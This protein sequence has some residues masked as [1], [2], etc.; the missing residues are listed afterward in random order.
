MLLPFSEHRPRLPLRKWANRQSQ[1][2]WVRIGVSNALVGGIYRLAGQVLVERQ[3]VEQRS[4]QGK[5]FTIL[6]PGPPFLDNFPL[7]SRDAAIAALEEAK[8]VLASAR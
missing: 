4:C 2:S 7:V 6:F 5:Q 8:S 3:Q 1:S